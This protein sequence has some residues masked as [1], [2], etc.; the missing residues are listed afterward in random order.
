MRGEE[1]RVRHSVLEKQKSLGLEGSYNA[2]LKRRVSSE[3]IYCLNK[4][5][6]TISVFSE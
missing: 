1:K 3:R 4:Q 6:R 5:K 2:F